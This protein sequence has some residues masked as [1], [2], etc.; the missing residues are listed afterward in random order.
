M[1]SSA[2]LASQLKA[3][4]GSLELKILGFHTDNLWNKEEFNSCVCKVLVNRRDSNIVRET[5]PRNAKFFP[6]WNSG[7]II[8]MRSCSLWDV[9]FIVTI[10]TTDMGDIMLLSD[11]MDIESIGAQRILLKSNSR[12]ITELVVTS[13]FYPNSHSMVYLSIG[14]YLT[15]QLP[16]LLICKLL[17]ELNKLAITEQL[18][19]PDL[20]VM[21]MRLVVAAD[22]FTILLT[23]ETAFVCSLQAAF[24]LP[25]RCAASLKEYNNSSGKK[26]FVDY[27]SLLQD[28][29]YPHEFVPMHKAVKAVE[30]LTRDILADE[31]LVSK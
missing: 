28:A 17:D 13:V 24:C 26:V 1:C 21:I 10:S 7:E 27:S 30:N 18:S 4:V 31:I 23:D 9:Q 25:H 20:S 15:E 29:A 12:A 3:V 14:Y 8:S 22:K 11:V 2:R 19:T 5:S 6:Q 16:Y